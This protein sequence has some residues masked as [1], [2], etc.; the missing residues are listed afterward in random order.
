[1]CVCFDINGF[2]NY[3]VLTRLS[4]LLPVISCYFFS[5]S[6]AAQEEE[7]FFLFFLFFRSELAKREEV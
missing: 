5:Y 2:D 1:M 3:D 4:S 7:R 6:I